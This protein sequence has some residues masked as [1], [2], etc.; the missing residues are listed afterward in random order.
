MHEV[1]RVV[2]ALGAIVGSVACGSRTLP[3]LGEVAGDAGDGGSPVGADAGG[4]D[5]TA[6]DSAPPCTPDGGSCTSSAQC[7]GGEGCIDSTCGGGATGCS[8][9]GANCMADGECC[10]GQC[11]KG[12]CGPPSNCRQDLA[13][14]S[15]AAQCCSL[16]CANHLCGASNCA[17]LGP[18]QCDTC[19]A[20][21]CCSELS[22]CEPDAM[23]LAYL[24][25]LVS[26]E[27]DGGAGESCSQGCASPGDPLTSQ[28]QQCAAQNCLTACTS[29]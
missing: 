8:P 5:S 20:L 7:C 14:C 19:M 12:F 24:Q 23:C 4:P 21:S 26:C 25:C 18:S 27:M 13:I 28:L 10:A 3:A 15:S 16:A 2:I 6:V 1:A 11:S 9:N 22:A 17:A 29:G